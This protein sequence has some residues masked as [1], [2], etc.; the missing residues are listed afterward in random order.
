MTSTLLPLK[1]LVV[2]GWIYRNVLRNRLNTTDILDYNKIR[3][4]LS[5][6]DMAEWLFINNRFNLNGS[7][8][9]NNNIE[10]SF[11]NLTIAQ[12]AELNNSVLPLSGT[13]EIAHSV[14][15]KLIGSNPMNSCEYSF[16]TIENTIYI[17]LNEGFMTKIL[18]SDYE[19]EFI[20]KYLKECY[21]IASIPEVSELSIFNLYIKHFKI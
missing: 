20:K 7:F 10:E 6:D 15:T 17:I 16:I 19:L 1:I 2:P 21:M 18:D 8:L 3:E 11:N 13:D 12:K 14:T 5:I 9:S 4:I